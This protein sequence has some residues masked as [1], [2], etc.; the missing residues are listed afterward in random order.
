MSQLRFLWKL[1]TQVTNGRES[2][3]HWDTMQQQDI[4]S[5]HR[6]RDRCV[7]S[8]V[9][10]MNQIHGLTSVYGIALSKDHKA[11]RVFLHSLN[12]S[13]YKSLS[14]V[15]KHKIEHAADEFYWLC[16]RIED[17]NK[18]LKT[19]VECHELCKIIESVPG[20]GVVNLQ[21]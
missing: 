21:A 6:M 19:I 8:R 1:A 14:A 18:Q 16:D 13:H 2:S 9:S 20:I 12:Q 3:L 11:F 15:L 7:S 17:I 10:L 5:L 4:Q